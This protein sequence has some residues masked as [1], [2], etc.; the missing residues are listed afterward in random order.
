MSFWPHFRPSGHL[1]TLYLLNCF[2]QCLHK[3]IISRFLRSSNLLECSPIVSEFSH[4]L[5][6]VQL[7]FSLKWFQSLTTPSLFVTIP[8]FP[9]HCR[10]APVKDLSTKWND[11]VLS[12]SCKPPYTVSD[13]KELKFSLTSYF[14]FP[15]ISTSW[16]NFGQRTS[17]CTCVCM[18]ELS[19]TW[20]RTSQRYLWNN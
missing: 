4:S 9:S 17:G 11:Q 14:S 12:L 15:R 5:K 6:Y 3:C 18:L 10:L 8:P 7:P 1:N 2:W 16:P 20:E 19:P 13:L